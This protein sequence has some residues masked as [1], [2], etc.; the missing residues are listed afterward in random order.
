M[1]QEVE[2][3]AIVVGTGISGGWAAKELT[4]KGLKTLVLERGRMVTHLEDYPTM[5][6]DPWDY[7][8][9]GDLSEA[10]K[11]KYHKQHRVGWAPQED[12]KH[13]FVNDLEH[14]Y[15]EIK[16]FDWIRGYQVGG[17]SLTW[18]RQSYRWSDID[19]EANGKDGHGVDWPVRYHDIAPWYDKVEEYIGVSGQNLGLK[20]LPDGKFQPP[21]ELNCAELE[22]QESLSEKYDDGRL[23]TIGRVAHITDPDADIEGRGVCQHRN[24]CWRGCPF[25]GYFSSNSSTLPAAERTGNMTLRANSIVYEVMYDDT[26]KKATGVKVIDAET[27]EK[28]EFKAKVIFL[29]ASAM[30]SV[31]ILLQSKSERFPNG[32]GNDSD[33]LGRNIMDHHYK[34]GAS[35][36]ISG[37]MNKYYK[38]RRANGFYIPRFVNLDENTKREG[39]LRGF[40]YQGRASREDWSAAVAELGY[41]AELKKKV[42]EPGAWEI[43]VTGFGEFLPYDSNRVTLSETEKDKWGLPQLAFDVEF[44]E[45]EYRMREDIKKEI[46][47]MFKKAGFNDVKPYEEETGPGLGI[48]EMGGAR[49]GHDAKTSILNKHNQVHLVP[50]V[51]VTDGAFMSSSGCVNPSLTYMAFT[52]RAANHAAEEFKAGKFS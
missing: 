26:T 38:G 42:L 14:P 22:F 28:L 9:K 51:Y 2:Y 23:L 8:L 40:G 29:C 30:A 41:G 47:E 24:R 12:V 36:K 4:E 39:Y 5:H 20:Q 50:N 27:N 16:R 52:A 3:D 18:G 25:G 11:K 43:G 31:G 33:A 17:R 44:K 7:A 35:A 19:F 13:F 48:H 15:V 32:L 10:D 46:M 37:H 34:L 21:M 1:N 49:M 6:D 45:N